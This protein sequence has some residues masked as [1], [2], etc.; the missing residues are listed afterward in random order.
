V[1]WRKRLR[2]VRTAEPLEHFFVLRMGCVGYDL[3][4]LSV[5]VDPAA[6]FRRT[7]PFPTE[8]GEPRLTL[9]DRI[10]AFKHDSVSPVIA[11]VVFIGSGVAFLDEVSGDRHIPAGQALRLV[12]VRLVFRYAD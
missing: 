5:S 8:T 1:R 6:V 12:E 9:A 3:Q 7:P 10:D 4:H 2:V 11:E